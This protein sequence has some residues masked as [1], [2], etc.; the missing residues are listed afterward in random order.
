MLRFLAIVCL[1]GAGVVHLVITPYH[2]GHAPAHGLFFGVLGIVQMVWAGVFW[3]WPSTALRVSGLALS[4]GVVVLW[5]LTQTVAIPFADQPEPIDWSLW[6]SKL[7]EFVGFVML[8]LS[9]SPTWQPIIRASG[10]GLGV[11]VLM[12]GGG[13]GGAV[14]FPQYGHAS[15]DHAG[16]DH[17]HHD[18]GDH[19]HSAES[20][21]TDVDLDNETYNWQLPEGFPLPAVPDDN[22]MTEEKVELGRFLFY[23]QRL[24]AN[25]TQ[26]CSSCHFQHLAFTDAKAQAVGST[27]EVHPRNAQTLTNVGYNATLTWANPTLTEL[28]R[29]ILVP[30]FGE[31]PHE[32]GVSG[33]EDEVLQRFIDDPMYQERFAQAFPDE[34]DPATWN[35]LVQA[36]AS[37]SRALISGN[38]P[39]DQYV[40]GGDKSALSPSAIRGLNL[41]MSEELECH[42]CHNGFNFTNSTRH[43]N[44]TF[45]DTPFEN[46][47]LYNIGGTGAYPR[48]NTGLHEITGNS[49]DMGRFRPPTLRNIELTGPYMHDGSIETLEEVIRF[50]EDG[51]RNI[52][53][54]PHAGDGRL[55]PNKSGFVPGF[56]L[57]DQERADVIEFLESLTDDQFITDPR[58]S[59][60]FA[61]ESAAH[62]P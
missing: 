9:G 1:F 49:E 11:G 35:N 14:L 41:F 18:H 12:W 61:G 20:A 33:H 4:G 56:V 32:L 22:P 29:Q 51:G 38:S 52:T 40:Y 42:H 53:T 19:D 48:G 16:H 45:K 60:P 7:F 24:S 44:T 62:T 37:F 21:Y 47:G 43:R 34:A 59:D 30:I 55:N 25:Q 36:L 57:T 39:Y 8:A 17:A 46:T 3:R 6:T 10:V 5:V 54:G 28:E 26:S 27:G 50:Y 58:F 2:Y 13:L 31:F 23:D 15:H